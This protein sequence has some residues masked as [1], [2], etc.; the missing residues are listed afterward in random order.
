MSQLELL[1]SEA[2]VICLGISGSVE[3]GSAV[4]ERSLAE[5]GKGGKGKTGTRTEN[6]MENGKRERKM[7]TGETKSGESECDGKGEVLNKESGNTVIS[8]SED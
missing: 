5:K 6:G 3:I 8:V 1:R 7:E 2:V 4:T